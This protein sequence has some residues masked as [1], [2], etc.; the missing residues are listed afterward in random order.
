MNFYKFTLN[1]S[2]KGHQEMLNMKTIVQLLIFESI[3]N[4][5]V[6]A[7]FGAF[8]IMTSYGI[9]TLPDGS[10]ADIIDATLFRN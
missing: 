4:H 5:C 3:L 10:F 8:W 9:T 6:N 1:K 2:I 7:M